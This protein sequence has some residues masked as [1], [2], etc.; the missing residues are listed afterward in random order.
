MALSIKQI[1]A[2]A[3]SK[4]L[5]DEDFVK[6][7]VQTLEQDIDKRLQA[8]AQF[9][10]IVYPLNKIS[11]AVSPKTFSKI[12][13]ALIELYSAPSKGWTIELSEEGPYRALVFSGHLKNSQFVFEHS[14]EQ[15]N[16]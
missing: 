11:S 7:T 15:N 13:K 10:Q 4:T 16:P 3:E 1:L 12:L 14:H 6:K 2:V 5:K 8:Q 9:A